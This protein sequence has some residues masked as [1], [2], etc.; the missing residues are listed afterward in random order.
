[1]QF[2]CVSCGAF[3]NQNQ[4]STDGWL[5]FGVKIGWS[6]LEDLKKNM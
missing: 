3:K 4:K 5:L 6:C 1:M 2:V